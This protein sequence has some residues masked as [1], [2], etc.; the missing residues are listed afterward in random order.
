MKM[1][2]INHHY[3]HHHY[4]YYC[5]VIVNFFVPFL[6][7][8]L[9]LLRFVDRFMIFVFVLVIVRDWVFTFSPLLDLSPSKDPVKKLLTG[10]SKKVELWFYFWI[11]WMFIIFLES[12][13]LFYGR[14]KEFS[15]G[16]SITLIFYGV[17]CFTIVLWRRGCRCLICTSGWVS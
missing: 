10:V 15:E 5:W 9:L 16:C 13:F 4:H 14:I 1:I 12:L 17:S 11:S 7:L 8:K 2:F 6:W 3:H